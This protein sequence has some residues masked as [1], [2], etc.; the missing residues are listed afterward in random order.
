MVGKEKFPDST[1]SRKEALCR[2]P[3]VESNAIETL[4]QLGDALEFS[5]FCFRL[6]L[7]TRTMNC[8]KRGWK[9]KF[10]GSKLF[11]IFFNLGMKRNFQVLR[12]NN[13][14]EKLF[15]IRIGDSNSWNLIMN[16]SLIQK[17]KINYF[18]LSS[19]TKFES[20]SWKKQ[21]F[22]SWKSKLILC[23]YQNYLFSSTK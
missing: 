17:L 10:L 14:E 13:I 16:D 2:R 7:S 11:E 15:T 9:E 20:S 12:R 3:I 18:N 6:V 22:K 23:F 1:Q 5:N 4:T 21:I 8:K 19:W